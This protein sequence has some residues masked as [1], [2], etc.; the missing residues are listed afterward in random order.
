MNPERRKPVLIVQHAPHEHPASIRRALETQGIQTLW[1]HPY[2]GDS[3]PELAQIRG[4]ISLGGPMGANDEAE[5]PWIRPEIE[6]L[7]QCV[8]AE[9]PT[10]GVCL[11]GQM[12]ARAMGSYVEK[13]HVAEVGWHPIELNA[14]GFQD[15]ILSAAGATPLVYHWHND[16]FHLPEGAVLLAKSEGCDRQA[17]RIGENAYG[18]QFHP[19]ADHHLVHEWLEAEDVPEEIAACLEKHGCE[20]VQVAEIQKA[21]AGEGETASLK[22]TA[23]I[24][25]LFQV[26]PY[27]PITPDTRAKI[28]DWGRDRTRISVGYEGPDRRNHTIVGS[29]SVL[30]TIPDGD[31]LFLKEESTTILWPLRL[32]T[33]R[34]LEPAN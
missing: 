9:L 34:S 22:I 20:R 26:R 11:G 14:Q 12:M 17:Y 27:S 4:M 13:N 32:D 7:R 6:L 18:F 28:K 16:T 24:G 15:R 30:L 33:I 29:I 25:Q 19:E 8:E 31:F 3:Y 5:H 23:A 1:I 21:K 2:R 10:V